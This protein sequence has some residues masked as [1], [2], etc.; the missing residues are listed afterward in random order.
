[1]QRFNLSLVRTDGGEWAN[2]DTQKANALAEHFANVFKPYNS[3]MSE[4]EEQEILHALETLGQLKTPVKKFKLTEVWTAIHQLRPKKTPGYDLITGRILKEQPDIGIW[5][6]TQIFNSVLRTVYFPGQWK[7]SQIITILKPGKPAEEAKSYRPISFLP[8]LSKL[9]EKLFLTRIQ[10][11]LQEKGIIPD[12]QFGFR[13]KH[14]TIEQVHRITNVIHNAL[15][16][17]K[18]CTAAFLGISQVFDK[19][20][21]EGLLYKIKTGFSD[22]TYKILKSYLENRYF[23]IK[24]MEEYTSLHPVPSGVPQGSILDPLLY[25]IYT[26]DLPTTSDSTTATFADDT[27]V[28]TIRENPAIATHRLQTNLNEI[29]LWLKNGVWR[30]LKQSQSKLP[31]P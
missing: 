24:Y 10:P 28:L 26:T 31:L 20:W 2:S 19:A 6:I 12:H 7:V 5:A 25:L 23:L 30:S 17:N 1:M 21:H 29:Q 22:S 8:I 11:T 27:A 18:Y 3:V 14:A 4:A 13:Q 9:C 15:E 16:S